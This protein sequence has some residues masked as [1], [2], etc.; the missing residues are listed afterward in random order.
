VAN[1]G[2]KA[3]GY[4]LSAIRRQPTIPTTDVALAGSESVD[5]LLLT[6]HVELN[7]KP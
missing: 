1:P 2:M 7:R 6:V 4:R 3:V 5:G